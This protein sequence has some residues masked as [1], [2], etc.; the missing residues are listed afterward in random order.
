MKRKIHSFV[1]L[2]NLF[3]GGMTRA[4]RIIGTSQHE[5]RK[6]TEYNLEEKEQKE[7]LLSPRWAERERDGTEGDG[8]G[9]RRDP[10]T[11]A[12]PDA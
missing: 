5:I 1:Y 8:R 7:R 12:R 6:Q 11:M 3:R 10:Q 4:A 9:S 2:T